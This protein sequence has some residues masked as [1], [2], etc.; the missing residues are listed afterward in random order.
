M[1]RPRALGFLLSL[2]LALGLFVGLATNA[3]ADEP[4]TYSFGH[5]YDC[6]RV[7]A[8]PKKGEACTVHTFDKPLI[9]W[10]RRA[11][12]YSGTWSLTYLGLYKDHSDVSSDHPASVSAQLPHIVE[13][14]K[15]KDHYDLTSTDN[16]PIFELKVGG[17]HVAYGVICAVAASDGKALYI[18]DTW[19]YGGGYVLSTDTLNTTG[20]TDITMIKDVTE[21]QEALKDSPAY[22]VAL[23]GGANATTSGG[24]TTQNGLIGDKDAMAEVTYTVGTGYH[25]DTFTDIVKNG[26]TAT[27]TSETTVKVS[28]IPTY[29]ASIE[30]PDAVPNTYTVTL[31]NQDATTPGATSVTA[32]YESPLPSIV[33]NLPTRTDY[34]FAGYFSEP[35][36]AGTQ[37]LNPDG[38]PTDAAWETAGAGTIYAKW[39]PA[40]KKPTPEATFTATDYDKG[41]LGNMK[42]GQQYRIDGGD[43]IDAP[44]GGAIDLT[45]LSPCTIEVIERG[46]GVTTVDSDIQRIDVTRSAKPTTPSAAD[47]TTL[48]NDDGALVGVTGDMQYKASDA[49]A[50]TSGDGSVVTGLG[51]GTYLVRTK[52]AGTVLA[53]ENLPLTVR[54]FLSHVVKFRVVNGTWADGT[55]DEKVVTLT[56]HEDGVLGPTA[57]LMP[58]TSTM[59]WLTADQI[60]AVGGNPDAGFVAGS[61]DVTPTTTLPIGA[62]TTFTYTYA[63]DDPVTPTQATVT[64]DA[65]GGTGAMDALP[66]TVGE[67]ATPPANAFTRDGYAFTGWNTKAD[68]TGTAYAD[69]AEVEVTE[70]LTLYAQ[71]TKAAPQGAP[72]AAATSTSK[73]TPKTGDADLGGMCALL[74]A[75]AGAALVASRGAR[76]RARG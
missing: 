24:D 9:S 67:T 51:S 2:V 37:Y 50:W 61:W 22:T 28:G 58:M 52:P 73:G 70:D 36:G 48:A 5:A 75:V 35:N 62:D 40:Q 13:Y 69:L 31:D 59:L 18:G 47:C 39:N 65:N 12:D 57:D 17:N 49:D 25:F 16:I 41:T 64:F 76:G 72:K 14:V 45:G 74:A 21:I 34:L 15:D 43:W 27:R 8:Y 11:E 20:S 10:G 66:V 29:N 54:S 42:E 63:P 44:S 56:G 26:I 32:T 71:W 3:R 38:T 33:G 30:I 60:P 19:P 6:Q 46:D 1:G 4:T 53:S 68:G 7:P 23:T 55:R